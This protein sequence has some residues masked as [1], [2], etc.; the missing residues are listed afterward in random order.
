MRWV[1]SSRS[2]SCAVAGDRDF[3]AV[4]FQIAAHDVADDGVV[5]GDQHPRHHFRG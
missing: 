1:P 3:E 5:V 4:A 2:A